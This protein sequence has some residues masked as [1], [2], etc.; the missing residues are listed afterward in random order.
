MRRRDGDVPS[1]V[2]NC[3]SMSRSKSAGFVR[4]C[5][6]IDVC[7]LIMFILNLHIK[8]CEMRIDDVINLSNEGLCLVIKFI[9]G[10]SFP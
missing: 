2:C 4:H 1:Y 6:A 9:S 10:P 3:L 7:G 5:S 8:C